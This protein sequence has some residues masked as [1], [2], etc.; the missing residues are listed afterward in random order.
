MSAPEGPAPEV[1]VFGQLARDLVLV[2]DEMPAAGGSAAVTQ[3]RE[4]PGSHAP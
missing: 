2:V 3:R 1:V 4:L